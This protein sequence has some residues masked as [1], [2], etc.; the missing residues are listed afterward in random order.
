M[1]WPAIELMHQQ[2]SLRTV[3]FHF[4]GNERVIEGEAQVKN[5]HATRKQKGKNDA[6]HVEIEAWDSLRV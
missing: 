4:D 5:T 2:T 6:A 1:K 3:I